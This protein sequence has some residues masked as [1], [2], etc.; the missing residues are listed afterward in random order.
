ML[1]WTRQ[2]HSKQFA[3]TTRALVP[4][5]TS[6]R[7]ADPHP[8]RF[9]RSSTSKPSEPPT[10]RRHRHSSVPPSAVTK[11]RCCD[12]RPRRAPGPPARHIA[13]TGGPVG[14]ASASRRQRSSRPWRRAQRTGRCLV[15][16]DATPRSQGRHT[17]AR[18]RAGRHAVTVG[19]YVVPVRVIICADYP[20][21]YNGILLP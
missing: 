18:A 2:Q 6:P 1:T 21:W 17:H 9:A 3:Q 12:R 4:M 20:N 8:R 14:G 11:P 15:V 13:F 19:E 16:R 5:P 7:I 10:P